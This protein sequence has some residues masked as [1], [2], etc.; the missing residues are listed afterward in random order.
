[1]KHLIFAVVAVFL[2]TLL[3]SC[4]SKNKMDKVEAEMKSPINCATAEAD[5]RMLEGEKTHAGEQLAAG[6]MAIVPASMVVGMATGT[7]DDKAKVAT[8]EYNKMIEARINEIKIQCN[9]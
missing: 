2:C 5:I 3:T 4:A 9:M 7:E 1:M 6:V 8:G